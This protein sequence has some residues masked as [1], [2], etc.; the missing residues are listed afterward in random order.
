METKVKHQDGKTWIDGVKGW[1]PREMADDIHAARY[2]VLQAIGIDVTYE[3]LLGVSGMAFRLQVTEVLCP[4]SANSFCGYRSC[5]RSLQFFPWSTRL[6]EFNHEDVKE[7]KEARA[8]VIDSINRGIPVHYGNNV[9]GVIIGYLN[10]GR[11]WL[12]LHPMEGRKEPFV[13]NELPGTLILPG[14]PKSGIPEKKQLALDALK[15]AVEMADAGMA[16]EYAVGFNAWE[17][18]FRKL[19]EFKKQTN[20]INPEMM[21]GNAWIYFSLIESR[22]A[23][24]KYLRSIANEFAKPAAEHLE[25]AATSYEQLVDSLLSGDNDSQR[26]APFPGPAA[27]SMSWKPEQMREQARR[28]TIAFELEK[29]AIAEIKEAIVNE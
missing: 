7:L 25:A 22:R 12:C 23:A 21:W 29:K 24:V 3:E 8:A 16:E 9:D 11:Q 6:F 10:D 17:L 4:S 20:P 18:W 2:T 5:V 19:D 13:K 27:D 15:Q 26:L 14:E 1:T 28:M